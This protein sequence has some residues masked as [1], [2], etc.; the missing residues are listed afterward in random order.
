MKKHA[1]KDR[2]DIYISCCKDGGEAL[3]KMIYDRITDMG[4]DAYFDAKIT[5]SDDFDAE[6]YGVIA[7]CTDVLLILPPHGLEHCMSRGDWIGREIAFALKH[8][9]NIIPI[10]M[11][12]FI[13]PDVLPEELSKLSYFYRLEADL[14][15]LDQ[16]LEKL[17]IFM[18]AKPHKKRYVK[19]IRLVAVTIT[20][21]IVIVVLIAYE[22]D[23]WNASNAVWTGG[24]AYR[25]ESGNGSKEYPYI[26]STP[27][28]LFCLSYSVQYGQTYKG[29]YFRLKNDLYLS[30][31]RTFDF[32]EDEPY[33]GSYL[34][35]YS[36]IP[37]GTDKSPF[38]GHFDGN[39]KTIYGLCISEQF[40]NYQGLFGYCSRDSVIS[41]LTLQNAD[42]Q[43]DNGVCIG[44]LVGYT[45]GLVNAC[46]AKECRVMG[47]NWVGGLIGKGSV[48]FNCG[49]KEVSVESYYNEICRINDEPYDV[50]HY[51][52]LGGLVAKCDY[53]INSAAVG[54]YMER[55]SN[56]SGALVGILE[57]DVYNCVSGG[58]ICIGKKFPF[59][60]FAEHYGKDNIIFSFADNIAIYH[61][62]EWPLYGVGGY[63]VDALYKAG[64]NISKPPKQVD[65]KMT[66]LI[67]YYMNRQLNLS[68]WAENK[69]EKEI[70]EKV[71]SEYYPNLPFVMYEEFAG[72]GY[73]YGINNHDCSS[74]EYG[75]EYNII[76]QE[77]YDSGYT[78]VK[79]MNQNADTNK[80]I[81]T[82]LGVIIKRCENDEGFGFMEWITSAEDACPILVGML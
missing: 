6:S 7:K 5:Y 22:H 37:I 43:C 26:I 13:W 41:N 32:R 46:F 33:A 14:D 67:K 66:Y 27:E 79:T 30:N 65:N 56:I 4:Y 8:N 70:V 18:R 21:L 28:Q 36:W 49:V 77:I 10:T 39:R 40:E 54:V 2:F 42:I 38:S 82:G 63:D 23:M 80:V 31:A 29:V 3:A 35:G 52:C 62:E 44:T 61:P 74:T 75:M 24:I 71:F 58:D 11:Q 15:Y 57:T 51:S 68:G 76:T 53:I 50:S 20:M 19:K 9:K 72:Q 59:H 78:T 34:S 55:P 16:F 69:R 25:Y 45:E 47:D 81:N 1:E 17:R 48:I 73:A 60:M 12:G 64:Y